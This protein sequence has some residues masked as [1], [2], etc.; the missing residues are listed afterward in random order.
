MIAAVESLMPKPSSHRRHLRVGWFR[1]IVVV[2]VI[3]VAGAV[4]ALMLIMGLGLVTGEEF[5]PD[6]FQQRTFTYY[7]IPLLRIQITPVFRDS[8]TTGVDRYLS[9]NGFLASARPSPRWHVVRAIG[10]GWGHWIGDAQILCNYLDQTDEQGAYV[11]LRWSKEHP[12]LAKCLWPTIV[13]LARENLY[14]F[15]PELMVLAQ[16][17]RDA[18]QLSR[19]LADTLADSYVWLAEIHQQLGDHS[20]AIRYFDQA[21]ARRSNYVKAV[22]GRARSYAALRRPDRS[23]TNP[24][25]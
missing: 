11:W 23:V 13:E 15:V 9:G 19:E 18:D 14:M 24:P 7:Q 17:A 5:S 22:E 12:E 2:C 25:R 4:L 1:T 10:A 16:S 8:A 3:L 20:N 6:T 21:L